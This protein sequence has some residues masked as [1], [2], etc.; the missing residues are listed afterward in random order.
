MIK[1]FLIAILMNG[2]QVSV[3]FFTAAPARKTDLPPSN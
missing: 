3:A 1:V 2:T